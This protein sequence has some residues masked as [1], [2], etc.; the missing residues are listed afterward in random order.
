MQT[1]APTLMNQAREQARRFG[2]RRFW[3]R[4]SPPANLRQR[5]TSPEAIQADAEYG[6][7]TGLSF[8]NHLRASGLDPVGLDT[9][10][11]GPGTGFG[12]AVVLT[13][14]GARAAVADRWLSSWQDDYHRP[15]YRRLADLL[16]AAH[17]EADI[18][19]IISLAEQGCYETGAIDLI[20]SQAEILDSATERRFDAIFSNAV[21][22]HV[23]DIDTSLKALCRLTRPGGHG[24]HQVDFRDHRNF[25]RPLDHLLYAKQAFERLS[26][27]VHMEYGSQRRPKEYSQAFETAGF[28]IEDYSPNEVA[29]TAYLDDLMAQLTRSLRSPHKNT[30]REELHDLSGLF[31]VRRVV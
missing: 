12:G 5:D 6:L 21:L 28:T 1:A 3:K 4:L 22:E 11:I 18:R 24:F 20:S 31:V 29:D 13:A 27:R 7:N 17:P 15:Y 10:E 30:S 2:L 26:Q 23:L 9:L 16:A 8:Y 14:F 19:P 25:S